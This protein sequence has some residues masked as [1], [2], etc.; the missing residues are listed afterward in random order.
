MMVIY[1]AII[2]PFNLIGGAA[3]VACGILVYPHAVVENFLIKRGRDNMDDDNFPD[4]PSRNVIPF[5]K[6]TTE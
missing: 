2:A 6:V 4:P 1:W 3:I 5:Y